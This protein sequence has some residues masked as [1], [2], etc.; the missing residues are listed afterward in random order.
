MV[1][2]EGD[3]ES[4]R[5]RI[6][7]AWPEAGVKIAFDLDVVGWKNRVMLRQRIRNM[8]WIARIRSSPIRWV[9]LAACALL[10]FRVFYVQPYV[11]VHNDEIH[12]AADG[13][14]LKS[15][16]SISEKVGTLF[17]R[18]VRPHPYVHPG[19][20]RLVFHGDKD[21]KFKGRLATHPRAG[22][23]P[24]YMVVLAT[25]YSPWSLDYLRADRKYVRIA[26]SVSACFDLAWLILLF[27]IL[28][29]KVS[30]RVAYGIFGFLAV[31][32]F[33]WVFGTL[34]YLDSLATF[35]AVLAAWI[36][37]VKIEH[38]GHLCHWAIIGMALGLGIVAK[39]SNI[40]VYP[41][42]AGVF[43]MFGVKVAGRQLV[44]G[45]A[46]ALG[47]S[48]LVV[49]VFSHPVA[50][51]TEIRQSTDP[52]M[53]IKVKTSRTVRQLSFPFQPTKH[54]HFG[55]ERH[56]IPI[57]KS[58]WIVDLYEITTPLFFGAF[59]VSTFVL[60]LRRRF[61]MSLLV[62]ALLAFAAS[63]PLGSVVRRI[64]L[65]LPF[66]ALVIATALDRELSQPGEA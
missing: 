32:P 49:P 38:G 2:Q 33:F 3:R 26:R 64:Y 63:V 53:R 22:H 58:P 34:A 12:Y 39:Q 54:Y 8:T 20:D 28:R 6:R 47:V 55:R 25:V 36:L 11:T 4:H 37:I 30:A 51:M 9:F 35:L 29:R 65:L 43:W 18:H 17:Y 42:L 40:A 15:N 1:K 23:P 21:A 46:V 16:L 59:W 24:L 56:G 7:I 50:L 10:V 48:L 60:L 62:I 45:A 14:W 5:T 13:L 41:L 27:D 52:A 44:V 57:V 66:M 31:M 61:K 19:T